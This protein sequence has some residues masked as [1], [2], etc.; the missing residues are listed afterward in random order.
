MFNHFLLGVIA[1]GGRSSEPEEVT[2]SINVVQESDP[3]PGANAV[4]RGG[5]QA[6][7]AAAAVT[8]GEVHPTKFL[9]G[10]DISGIFTTVSA[11]PKVGWLYYFHVELTGPDASGMGS[12]LADVQGLSSPVELEFVGQMN[13]TGTW[14][15]HT[16]LLD[17]SLYNN[18]APGTNRSVTLK[19]KD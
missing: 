10:Y 15:W 16:Q 12:L 2:Y 18:W 13:P 6:T 3:L 17:A 9:R 19:W 1:S 4:F 5:G 8:L 14:R 7:A 11:P